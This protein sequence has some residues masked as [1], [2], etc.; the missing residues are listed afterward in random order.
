MYS[1]QKLLPQNDEQKNGSLEIN[2]D[3][4]KQQERDI[5]RERQKRNN[6]NAQKELDRVRQLVKAD[7]EARRYV[8][9]K[10]PSLLSS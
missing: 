1:H 10:R 4:Q 7:R 5:T 8:Y 3:A 9:A 6:M 2:K